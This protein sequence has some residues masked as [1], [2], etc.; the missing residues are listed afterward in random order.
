[1]LPVIA[2][3]LYHLCEVSLS[4]KHI[5]D[6]L[7]VEVKS[8]RGQLN[9]V[10]F[11]KPI[12][13][14]SQELVCSSAVPLSDN[15]GGNQLRFGVNR[16]ENP[17]ISDF[18]RILRFYVTL[19]LLAERPDFIALNVG[20]AKI[21][22]LRIHQ[23]YAPLTSENQQSK[24]RIAVKVSNAFY[25]ANTRS[26]NQELNRQQRLILRDCHRRKQPGVFLSIGLLALRTAKP[27]KAVAMLPELPAFDLARLAFHDLRIQQALA[28]C[29]EEKGRAA[30]GVCYIERGY[31]KWN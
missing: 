7:P 27:L 13:K 17:S 5:L 14:Q 30:L 6:T 10:F 12:S 31:P 25:T 3:E 26:L 16:N 9:A 8:V 11:C 1:M 15:V 29:Q 21:P 28:V 18:W 20:T 2:V 22:H 19:F 24:D 23:R 4:R